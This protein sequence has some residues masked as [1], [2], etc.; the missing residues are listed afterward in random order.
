MEPHN[1][2]P[3]RVLNQPALRTSSGTVWLVVGALFAALSLI[4]LGAL[5]LVR[6]GPSASLATIISIAVIG[7]YLAMIVIRVSVR[8]QGIRLRVLMIVFLAMAATALFGVLGCVAL[9]RAA[10]TG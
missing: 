10:G 7:L 2:D 8:A 6:Q 9:E 3:T 4:P 5:A 1:E